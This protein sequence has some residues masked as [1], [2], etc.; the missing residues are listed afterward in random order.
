MNLLCWFFCV[1]FFLG[2]LICVGLLGYVIFLQLKMGL[3]LCLLC[4]FQWLVFV[5]LGLLFL[6]GVLYG[7]FN[8]FGW[9]IYGVFVFIVVVVGV[10]IVVCYVYVQMLLLEM[11]VIC[12]LLLSFLCEIMGL[13][14]VFCMVFIGIGNCG[15]IDWMFLGLIMLMWLGV[16]F[17]LL[18]LWV[19]VVLLFKIKC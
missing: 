16:W 2:F 1:Q 14:E 3:E 8:C 15:N 6:I 19:L 7:F 9:V 12:G 4:I 5:V 18:V 11:G 17:V 10:G 13:L